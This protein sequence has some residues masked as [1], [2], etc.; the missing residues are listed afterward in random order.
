MFLVLR[1]V[2]ET[3]LIVTLEGPPAPQQRRAFHI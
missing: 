3:P 1:L 2:A